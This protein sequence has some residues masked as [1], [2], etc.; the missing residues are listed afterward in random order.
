MLCYR[1]NNL[2]MIRV[3]VIC[4]FYNEETLA[5]LF[6]KH[7]AW[8]DQI[9][10]IVSR[11]SDRT[12]EWLE[13][14][15]N[16]RVLDFEFPA[17]M[18][19][20]IKTQTIN[21]LITSSSPFDWLIVVDSDEFIWSAD[22]SLAKDYLETVSNDITVIKAKMRNVFRHYSETDIDPNQDPVPQRCHGDP[23]YQSSG[24]LP[25]QKPIIIR[26]NHGITLGLGNHDQSGG[27]ISANHW[28]DGSHWQNADPSLAITRRI[29]DRR[30]RQ[31]DN[32]LK[33]GLGYHNHSITTESVLKFC[34]E[35]TNCPKI[36]DL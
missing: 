15:P 8:A 21:Q 5:R 23:D 35:R 2:F 18:D 10:A 6:I 3:Q 16:V 17:G 20:N 32:N 12:R 31:S 19:D 4:F 1:A 34:A 33:C 25:Y 22:K 26:A 36:I 29:R 27:V 28:F 9:L 30:D 24:N 13:S 14:A 7:Y 11:S